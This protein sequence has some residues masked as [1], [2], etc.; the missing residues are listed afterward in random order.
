MVVA[1]PAAVHAPEAGAAAGRAAKVERM[2]DTPAD[3]STPAET[4]RLD[5]AIPVLA[6]LGAVLLVWVWSALGLLS[7]PGLAL[8]ALVAAAAG[9][10]VLRRA[11]ALTLLLPPLLLPLPQ[12]GVLFPFE[13]ALLASGALLV[14]HLAHHAPERLRRASRWE[15]ANALFVAWALVTTLW[16][17]DGLHVF[18]GVRRLL[19]GVVAGAVA[20]RMAGSVSKRAFEAGVVG[21]LLALAG[22]TLARSIAGGFTADNAL[23]HRSATTA[24]GWGTANFIATLLLLL[25]PP[26]F[27]LLVSPRPWWM[28]AG[29]AV[30]LLLA[31]TLQ[32]VVASRAA[33]VLFF[34]GLL[35]QAFL[36][37]KRRARW[38]GVG[39]IVTGA[40]VAMVSPFGQGFLERFTNLKD[41]GSMVIRLWYFREGFRRVQDFFWFGMG[42]NQGIPYPDKMSGI[43]LHNYWLVVASE[44]GV[45]GLVLWI[46]TLGAQWFAL[47][48]VRRTP[49]F[50]RI[51]LSL[52]VAFWL[53]QLHTLV[54]PTFQGVQYQFLWFWLGMG[55]VGY[56][57]QAASDASYAATS[58]R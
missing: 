26:A 32:V 46:V 14:L 18:L 4:T 33:T 30:G 51:G 40:T 5:R 29:A 49:G 53:G 17:F 22:A 36:M 13:M 54:E 48:D 55:F 25:S 31:A 35:V 21:M 1:V 9:L 7:L 10:L 52:Q 23:E 47:R 43:D 42:L 38:M 44:L 37:L 57:R 58:E 39:A 16:A 6:A 2:F 12:L 15:V 20:A 27:A 19:L 50:E 3:P 34:L 41:L 11:P 8:A 56:A 28:R 24:M 45:V